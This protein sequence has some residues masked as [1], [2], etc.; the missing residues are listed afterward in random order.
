MARISDE[1]IATELDRIIEIL[2]DSGGALSRKAIGEAYLI[3]HA[4]GLRPRTLQ[5]RLERLIAEGKIRPEGDNRKTAYRYF[6]TGGT[7]GESGSLSS[8]SAQGVRLMALVKRPIHDRTPVGYDIDWLRSYRPGKTW[9]L[10]KAHRVRLHA[11]GRT[12]ED[13]RPAGTFA[14]DILGRLLIDLSWASSRLE[15]N[16]YN[17]LDTQNLL[18]FGQAAEGKDASET[19]MILNHKA[20]I[21]Y[22]VEEAA[23]DKIRP[24]NIFALHALLSENLLADTGNEGRLR[25][26]PVDISGSSYTP[27]AI[28]QTITEAFERIV[29]N[30]KT[31]PDPF[32]QALFAMVH[33]T[34][35]QPFV[36]VNKRTSRL[37]ANLCLLRANMC[38]LSF[39]G[40]DE[41]WYQ[42][43][44][45]AVYEQRSTELLRDFFLSA[46]EQSAAKYGVVRDSP[47][48]PDPLRLK[49]RS[50]LHQVVYATVSGGL[51]PNRRFLRELSSQ[52]DVA[53]PDREKF[54]ELAMESLLSLNVGS[55]VRSG[56]HPGEFHRW[57]QKVSIRNKD[58]HSAAHNSP[59][60]SP[61]TPQ[62][63]VP[64]RSPS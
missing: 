36:D 12:P 17:Q 3:R 28:P 22:M 2:R 63:Q 59:R 45:L 61:R 60:D 57:I 31:I 33:L 30:L 44:T 35:L 49:Y 23:G 62:R 16:T 32:E 34:F 20:A 42:L 56:L 40:A 55:A 39:V 6:G 18:E 25:E 21:E 52:L 7:N 26:R 13:D 11:A 24:A 43:G 8:L 4:A 48:T 53:E 37:L 9:Y 41:E 51:A 15:G 46:Y 50:Q 27:T 54:V 19:Q 64:F 29:V 38:P 1:A 5:R 58:A 10:S 14:R 47:P